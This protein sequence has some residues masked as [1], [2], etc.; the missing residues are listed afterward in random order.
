SGESIDA[1]SLRD[2][3][4][5]RGHLLF[6]VAALIYFLLQGLPAG[7]AALYAVLILLVIDLLRRLW[8]GR[9]APAAAISEC[10]RVVAQGFV[11]GARSGATVAVVI[12][13]IGILVEVMTITG[14]AQN[15][16]NL[17]LDLAG[18]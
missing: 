14:F 16:S 2:A 13:V 11:D 15:L 9:R 1:V 18:G 12:A 10:A 5:A 6:G 3:L 4:V 7:T 8:A 17:M